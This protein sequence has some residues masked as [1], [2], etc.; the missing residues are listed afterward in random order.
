LKQTS[1]VID[2]T[3][4]SA[5]VIKKGKILTWATL[6]VDNLSANESNSEREL[7]FQNSLVAPN[8]TESTKNA[9]ELADNDKGFDADVRR[10]PPRRRKS[11]NISLSHG[12]G[13][14]SGDPKGTCC[15]KSDR[16]VL[17]Q[18]SRLSDRESSKMLMALVSILLSMVIIIT[19]IYGPKK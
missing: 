3:K 19:I 11:R 4:S 10:L 8:L 1:V 16:S 2:K 6:S 12:M 15:D 7:E 13:S 17:L 5:V 18:L 14:P 9:A